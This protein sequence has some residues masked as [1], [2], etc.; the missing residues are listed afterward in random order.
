MSKALTWDRHPTPAMQEKSAGYIDTKVCVRPDLRQR[1]GHSHRHYSSRTRSPETHG[2]TYNHA[3]PA[4]LGS[5][6]LL[7]AAIKTELNNTSEHKAG[8][9]GYPGRE[10]FPWTGLMRR[11]WSW[12]PTILHMWDLSFSY[13]E[14]QSPC[15]CFQSE[16]GLKQ[17]QK[18]HI[19]TII[20]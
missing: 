11:H 15:K 16:A 20:I 17:F 4:R 3:S 12:L 7:L 13:R 8:K 2:P 9:K 5:Q 10:S 6:P 18:T 19:C 1:G 14:H